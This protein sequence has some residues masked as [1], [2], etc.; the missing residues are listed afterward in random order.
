ML[1]VAAPADSGGNRFSRE[2]K[3]DGAA[4][5]FSE[6]SGHGILFGGLQVTFKHDHMPHVG[7][8]ERMGRR[9]HRRRGFSEISI[10]PSSKS[11]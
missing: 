1:A 8:V 5:A 2:A 10:P 4:E 7:Q 11:K 3:A 9:H 6:S